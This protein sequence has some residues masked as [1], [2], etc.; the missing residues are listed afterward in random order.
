MARR[1]FTVG[2]SENE[3]SVV[4][5]D[6]VDGIEITTFTFQNT[7][8]EVCIPEEL[9]KKIAKHFNKKPEDVE[10]EEVAEYLVK[11]MKIEEKDIDPVHDFSYGY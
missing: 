10:D 8:T 9:V 1:C 3:P 2:G 4:A 6:N 11:V 7:Q 5:R